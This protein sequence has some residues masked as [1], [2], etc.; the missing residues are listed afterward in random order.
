[1]PNAPFILKFEA[2]DEGVI[3][4]WTVAMASLT[5]E[6]EEGL[7]SHSG[8]EEKVGSLEIGQPRF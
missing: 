3:L 7:E 8:W 2:G 5:W 6:R 1:L 4:G